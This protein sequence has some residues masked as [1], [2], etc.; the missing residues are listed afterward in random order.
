MGLGL[1]VVEKVSE[2][3]SCFIV[4]VFYSGMF[5]VLVFQFY[6]LFFVGSVFRK[7]R[8]GTGGIFVLGLL[9]QFWCLIKWEFLDQLIDVLY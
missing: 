6:V 1:D 7:Q 3:R 4:Y 9:G 5:I 8:E 2:C